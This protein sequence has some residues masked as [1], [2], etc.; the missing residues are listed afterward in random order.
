[1][2]TRKTIVFTRWTFVSKVMASKLTICLSVFFKTFSPKKIRG[3]GSSEKRIVS[4]SMVLPS[5]NTMWGKQSPGASLEESGWT[6]WGWAGRCQALLCRILAQSN[7]KLEEGDGENISVWLYFHM[8]GPFLKKNVKTSWRIRYGLPWWLSGKESGYHCRRHGFNP[9]SGK[10][11]HASEALS[12]S[13]T[14]I[15]PA[16]QSLG[17]ATMEPKCHIYWSLSTLEPVLCNKRSHLKE[18]PA[19]H[20]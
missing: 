4:K 13:T 9:W 3:E 10:I 2:T 18:K 6:G 7:K 20:N 12:P 15:E 5:W 8:D 19:P 1:M 14:T 17:A 11:S 16:L